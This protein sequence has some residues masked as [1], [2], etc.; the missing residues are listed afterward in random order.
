MLETLKN[1]AFGAMGFRPKTPSK[2]CNKSLHS[3]MN[4]ASSDE[5]QDDLTGIFGP[6]VKEG[7]EAIDEVMQ[8]YDKLY[9]SKE[10]HENFVS[11]EGF[12]IGDGRVGVTFG[13]DG[14]AKVRFANWWP[15]VAKCKSLDQWQK[16]MAAL[17]KY[18]DDGKNTILLDALSECR[19]K[20]QVI[21][22]A[23][24]FMDGNLKVIEEARRG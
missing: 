11:R 23:F 20:V 9:I 14:T 16:K 4:G 7:Q 2:S 22:I 21:K 19:H 10:M 12:S 13:A 5:E 18:E 1:K 24:S 15:A 6:D 3:L 8:G 17:L